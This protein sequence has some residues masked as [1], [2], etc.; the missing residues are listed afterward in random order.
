M[1]PAFYIS[2]QDTADSLK[3]WLPQSGLLD[4]FVVSTPENKDLVKDAADI[5]HV[6]GMLDYSAVTDP[7][8]KDLVNMIA[9]TNG[10]HGKVIIL[11]EQAATRENVRLLQ[12]LAST[13][14]VRTPSDTNSLLTAYT[15]GVNG[16]VVDD[17]TAALKAEEFFRDDAP[18]LLRIP[19]MIGHRGDPSTFVENTIDS[20]KGAAEE[21][22]DSVENDIH[23]STDGKL[24]IYHDDIGNGILGLRDPE[25]PNKLMYVEDLSLEQLREK[26][27]A[28]KNILAMNEVSQDLSRY[29]KFFGQDENKEYTVPTLE[30]YL[31]EFKGTG[32]IHD[33]EIKSMNPDII[34][35]FKALVDQYDAWDQV[36]TI[37]FNKP[38]LDEL[39]KN[40]PEISIGALGL[41]LATDVEYQNFD[42]LTEK[43]GPEEALKQLYGEIDQWNA[44]YN[45]FYFLGLGHDMILAG[46]H[47]GLTVWPWT[48]S[49]S[50]AEC[51]A[52]DYLFGVTGLTCDYPWIAS[53]YITAI[54]SDDV[55]VSS[56][57]EIPKPKGITQKGEVKLLEEAV[58]VKVESIGKNQ[59]LMIWRYK[60]ELTVDTQSFGTYYLY[61]N[62]FVCTLSSSTPG[63]GSSS[64]GNTAHPTQY[65]IQ[66]IT[67]NQ[68]E[69]TVKANTEKAKAG[70]AVTVAIT[71]NEGYQFLELTAADKNGKAI[72]IERVDENTYRFVMPASDVSLSP[73]FEKTEPVEN[74]DV[75]EKYMDVPEMAWY[76]DAVQWAADNGLMNGVSADIF[77]PDAPV[78]RAMIVTILYRLE[79][80]PASAGTI[81][82]D[83]VA[84]GQWYT[85][86][87]I[88][89]NAN[90]I[91][92]GYGS[93]RFG[94]MDNITREQFA[95]IMYRY[96]E[97][98]GCDVSKK[99]DLSAYS[100]A[101]EISTWAD[102]A[103]QWANGEGL[104]TGRTTSALAPQGET[105]RA[106]AAA[107]L[108]RYVGNVK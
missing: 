17:Y 95:A 98:K 32:V 36:F 4:C 27:F 99:A 28:W 100:D 24:F 62:P 21:G 103:M 40:Y 42:E 31:E 84:D 47:R 74:N 69:G 105:S 102:E 65:T 45:N 6:R 16:V 8:R 10:A 37:T 66:I 89:A 83:D 107:I 26:P 85:D 30:E 15:N 23:L 81:S 35:V 79:G 87:V 22:A 58:P 44:T 108:M 77:A 14:W 71:P 55:T 86:A 57:S 91:V 106:E 48:Y 41:S 61:S 101:S 33:T 25:D 94:P 18:S 68:T 50:D 80:E 73:K 51:F 72:Q 60:A 56:V 20:A 49:L 88:W 59:D 64:S 63:R 54:T 9:S 12:S 52:R 78:T 11:S 93:G 34:P 19:F 82:F 104:I 29:G 39:Y 76:H 75:S 97:F 5:L 67:D 92:E 43:E 2:D 13:V 3:E 7:D 1:I 70:D 53:D 90:G 46:R 38:I 96:S